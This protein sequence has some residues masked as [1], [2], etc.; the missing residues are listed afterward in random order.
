MTREQIAPLLQFIE[1]N[2]PST[3]GYALSMLSYEGEIKMNITANVME[4]AFMT[5]ASD[6]FLTS[7]M[8]QQKP[9]AGHP[10]PTL[11]KPEAVLE[12]VAEKEVPLN[13]KK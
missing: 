6:N 1:E 12:K 2:L 10:G 5:K 13:E 7:I 3:K 4:I 11:V 8:S 9:I